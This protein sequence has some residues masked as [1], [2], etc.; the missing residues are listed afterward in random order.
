MEK[1]LKDVRKKIEKEGKRNSIKKDV[2]EKLLSVERFLEFTIN[3]NGKYIPAYRCQHSSILGPYKGGIRFSESVTRDE[4]EALSILMTL[5]CA[6]INIPFGGGKG[7]AVIDPRKLSQEEREQLAREYVRGVFPVIGPETDIPAPDI[8]TNEEI[9]S[10]MVDE[11]SKIA[12]KPSLGAFT[13]KAVKL[14][15]LEGRA[16]AT[17][18][19]GFSVLEELCKIREVKGPRIAIQGF[20]NVG[21]NFA[22]F[23][24]EGGYKIIAVS[25][26]S[27]GVKKEEG[28]NIQKMLDGKGVEDAEGER[29]S[30]EELL[31][32]EVDVLVLAAVENVITEENARKVRAKNIISIANGPV[33]RK[34][35]K[36]LYKKG[37]IVVPDILASSGGV[38]ASYYEWLQAKQENKFNRKEVFSFVAKTIKNSFEVIYQKSLEQGITLSKAGV[39]VALLRLEEVEEG[40]AK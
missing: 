29:I 11:Y 23:A 15:G 24:E 9:I 37:I 30:N 26:H 40:N 8:N 16:E 3:L 10:I 31:E 4:V 6:L 27:G 5:K 20:G 13:G 32:M 34:A 17:G 18:Y 1:F 19:G 25:D 33:T 35:E 2:V 14:G 21:S 39:S 7:G 38:A 28:L 22:R 36:I 12:G